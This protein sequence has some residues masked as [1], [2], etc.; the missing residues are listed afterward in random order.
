MDE[1][2]RIK[3]LYFSPHKKVQLVFYVPYCIVTIVH[4]CVALA[5]WSAVSRMKR[6]DSSFQCC[7]KDGSKP[8]AYAD[9][10]GVCKPPEGAV[11]KRYG[12]ERSGKR[13]R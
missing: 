1:Y 3:Y 10:D 11:F 2:L 13:F 6:M 7:I 12:A 4:R 5:P 8:T 9:A